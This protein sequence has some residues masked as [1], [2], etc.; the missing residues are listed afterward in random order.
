[1]SFQASTFLPEEALI[2]GLLRK[3]FAHGDEGASVPLPNA[4]PIEWDR[5]FETA[6]QWNI[7]PMLYRLIRKRPDVPNASDIPGDALR[8][9]EAAYTKTYM[10]NRANFSELAKIVKA[11]A[12]AD[13]RV[14]LLK[15]AHLAQFVYPDIGLRWMADIDILI[16]RDDLKRA[17]RVLVQMGYAYPVQEAAVWDDFG[18]KK[19]IR[20]QEALVDWYKTDHMHLIYSNPNGIQT[21]E[22]HWGI[23]KSASP[24]TIHT[25]GL[26]ERAR[27]EKMNG[28][29]VW[30]LSPEDL[31]LHISLHDAYYHRLKLFGLRPCCDVAAVV[32]RFSKEINWERLQ[33]RARE[34]GMEKYLYM[35][36]RLS[37][38]L[39]G[40][41]IP[42][43]LLEAL[44]ERTCTNRRFLEGVRRIFGKE[45]DKPTYRGMKYP[46]KIHLFT[47]DERLFKK[48]C[49]FLRRIPI[50]RQELASRYALPASSRRIPFYYLVRFVS[51]LFSYGRVYAPYFWRQLRHG[52]N[53][54]ADGTLDQWLMSPLSK[55]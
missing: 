4:S 47:H 14:L 39:I 49:F 54:H 36:L 41:D 5:V 42:V 18:E 35:T 22:I 9:I 12:A 20:D 13:V 34:W 46:S 28:A 30:V 2:V 17:V 45:T 37:R 21:L 8:N 43:D 31:L 6:L 3:A 1:M 15:G 40:T 50:S 38:E 23:A 7:A 44:G 24:F 25:E 19:E 32:R 48:I 33:A 11:L 16:R 27:V 52:Q 55:E 53:H 29:S 26:W 51:L 10:V